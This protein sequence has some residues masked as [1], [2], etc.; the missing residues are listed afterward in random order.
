MTFDEYL[1]VLTALHIELNLAL[2]IRAPASMAELKHLEQV[3][4]HQLPDEL[5]T[6]WLTTDGC[7][8][9]FFVRPGYL[10][11]YAFL[12]VAEALQAREGFKARAPRYVEWVEHAPRDRR[13]KSGWFHPGWLPFASFFGSLVLLV[14]TAPAA[15]GTVG[16]IIAFTHDPDQMTYVAPSFGALLE[17]SLPWIRKN[18]GDRFAP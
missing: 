10:T 6:A 2:T 1:R 5:R 12:S 16:Q 18:T 11:G 15:S 13:I 17:A 14:D 7:D 9:T 4:G 3:W 8:Q